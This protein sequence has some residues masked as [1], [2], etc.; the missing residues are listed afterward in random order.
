MNNNNLIDDLLLLNENSL[1]NNS[2]NDKNNE[3]K[4]MDLLGIEDISNENE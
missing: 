2:I 3:D 4:L 1:K